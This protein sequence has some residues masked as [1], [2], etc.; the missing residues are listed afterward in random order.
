VAE[1]TAIAPLPAGL[2]VAELVGKAALFGVA[3]WA[4]ENALFGPRNSVA[5]TPPDGEHA[6]PA[7]SRRVVVPFLPVY[8]V[9]GAVVLV[10]AQ[11]VQNWPWPM[12]GALY[13]G[14]LTGLEYVACQIDRKILG[15]HS[16]DYGGGACVDW[17]H[18][19][20]WAGLGLLAERFAN[21]RPHDPGPPV[22]RGSYR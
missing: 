6:P 14:V 4:M 20:A 1:L 13:G 11:H 5:W 22:P 18:A 2:S 3:G 15:A 21:A 17:R 12:R 19:A 9:G 7:S 8:A 10:A 16:W